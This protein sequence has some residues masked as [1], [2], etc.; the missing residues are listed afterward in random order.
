MQQPSTPPSRLPRRSQPQASSRP[1]STSSFRCTTRPGPC[2]RASSGCT[3]T[4][5]TSSRSAP[6]SRSPTTAAPTAPGS[7]PS[8]SPASSPTS[9]A[10]TSTEGPRPRAARRVV[11]RATPRVLAYMDVD[12]STDLAAL[13]PLVAPLLSGHSDL[14][15]GTPPRPRRAV[16]RGAEAGADLAVA[17]TCS[18][19][20]CCARVSPMPSAASRRSGP[21]RP[22][23]FCRSSQDD[24]LVLRHRAARARRARR[25]AHPRGAG[26]LGRRPRL[27]ASTSSRPRSRTC[28]AST[29]S[30]LAADRRAARSS[31]VRRPGR[32]LPRRSACF[33]TAGT[34][35]CSTSPSARR[36]PG[37]DRKRARAAQ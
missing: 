33:S 5:P 28:G 10:C 25:P 4:S 26:R 27:A 30:G 2:A 31:R 12:L 32:A 13:L 36:L 24:R 21:T 3:P 22:T 29:C 17:T 19:I 14:A 34:T 9:R 16:V 8:R 18:C 37:P 6:G 11:R 1:P 15:I 23:S 35:R 7:S 20:S